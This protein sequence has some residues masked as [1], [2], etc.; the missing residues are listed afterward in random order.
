MFKLF[1]I[2][3]VLKL[4]ARINIY[5]HIQ[6][7]LHINFFVYCKMLQIGVTCLFFSILLLLS[8][9]ATEIQVDGLY[10]KLL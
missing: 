9:K 3:F 10:F 6:I 1:V 2:L 5:N 4:Y 8:A 7:S